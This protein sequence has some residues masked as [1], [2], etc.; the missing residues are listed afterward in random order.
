[1]AGRLL[2]SGIF[3]ALLLSSC[4]A[5]SLNLTREQMLTYYQSSI[6]PKLPTTARLLLSDER[7]N[8]YIGGQVLGIETARG[9]LY[10]FETYPVQDPTIVVTVN[11]SAVMNLSAGREGILSAIGNGGIA[12]RPQNFFSALKVEAV[13][14][15]YA[16]SGAD[17][18]IFGAGAAWRL[19]QPNAN[20]L[21][22]QRTRI[23]A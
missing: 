16:V 9:E 12:I 1:M 5:Y 11:D 14:R 4:S 2:A 6:E 21:Y 23:E 18:R 13:E 7:I 15:I 20:S 8:V 10:S 17:S 19:Q 22:V 3:L